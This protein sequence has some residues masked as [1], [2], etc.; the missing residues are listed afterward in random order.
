M[1]KCHK[2]NKAKEKKV[3]LK[4]TIHKSTIRKPNFIPKKCNS[5]SVM[6]KGFN[7]A[8]PFSLGKWRFSPQTIE[9]NER[10]G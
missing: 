8:L 9:Y 5:P 2:P 3:V 10:E 7:A 6:S 1:P 4:T